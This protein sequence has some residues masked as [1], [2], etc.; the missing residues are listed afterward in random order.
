[1]DTLT[2]LPDEPENP[3]EKPKK[4]VA[5]QKQLDALAMARANRKTKKTALEQAAQPPIVLK[6]EPIGKVVTLPEPEPEVVVVKKPKSKPKPVKPTIIQFESDDSS[7]SDSDGPPPQPT[8]II[9]NG[10]KNKEP[11][12]VPVPEPP[13]Q[14]IRRAY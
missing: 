9:R 5:S 14:Y 8:I 7:S 10:K 4:R 11:K 2:E 13:R 1:M 3:I 6:K 12:A